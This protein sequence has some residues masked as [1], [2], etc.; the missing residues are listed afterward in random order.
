MRFS[1]FATAMLLVV[2]NCAMAVNVNMADYGIKPDRKENQSGKLQKALTAIKKKY[3]GTPVTLTFQKGK[4]NFLVKGTAEREYYI[5]NHSQMNPRTVGFPIEDWND[6]TIDGQGSDFYFSGH[7]LPVA[8]VRSER[9]QLKN[10]S[11]DFETPQIA[12]IEVVSN[13]GDGV[14]W[15]PAPWVKFR[16]DKDGKFYNQGDG[17]EI[18][19]P[20]AIAFDG[21]TRHIVY[22][23]S[24]IWHSVDSV[25]KVG[26]NLYRSPKWKDTKMTPGTVVALHW[27]HRPAAGIFVDECK[28]TKINDV[29]IHYCEGM[30]L[31]AQMSENITLDGFGVCLRGDDDPRYFTSN[32][33]ATHFSACKGKIVSINGLYEGMMDDAINVHGSYLRVVER[34]NAST[35]VGRYL[36][37]GYF[38]FKWGEEGDSVR[39]IRSRT[40]ENLDSIY[41]IKSIT[42]VGTSTYH[43]AK[44]FEI[45][46]NADLPAEVEGGKTYGLENITWTPEVYFAG[47]TIRNNRARGALFST[48]KETIV[49]NNLFDHTSGAAILLAGDCNG[50]YETGACRDVTIRNNRFVNAL[51]NMFQFTEA[52]ISIYPEV[53]ELWRQVKYFHGGEGH[54]GV[55]I[56]N[57][58]FETF[59][60]PILYAKS[61]DGIHFIGNKVKHNHDFPAFHQNKFTFK[62]ERAVNVTIDNNDFGG[63]DPSFSIQ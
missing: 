49:E 51:T 35:V 14:V 3:N 12:Q 55:V 52:I 29:K 8:L 58:V 18:Q 53:P 39:V 47:N 45:V 5:S 19:T 13:D 20:A 38:G 22:R 16:I 10:F 17:W 37:P 34:K 25:V 62:L 46:F 33:D 15:K 42:P 59:D 27:G 31:I 43:G 1:F 32:A 7:T 56:E 6:V 63:V 44:D 9:V 2:S 4:Y 28:D 60:N 50:W 23:T 40:M 30:G 48:P 41:T 26:D 57:N 54:K 24:D 11:V 61:I 36:S 21:K